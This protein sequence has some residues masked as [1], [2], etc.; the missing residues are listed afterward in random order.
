MTISEYNG[1]DASLSLIN[2]T[3]D[4][5]TLRDTIVTLV[6]VS[7]THTCTKEFLINT[8]NPHHKWRKGPATSNRKM[9]VG[10]KNITR[11]MWL[12]EP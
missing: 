9:F 1:T 10:R 7:S 3:A 5:E 12:R 4:E 8:Y 2:N 6:S 11:K